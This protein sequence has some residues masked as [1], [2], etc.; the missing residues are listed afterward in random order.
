MSVATHPCAPP[1]A[2]NHHLEA[3][4]ALVQAIARQVHA[5]FRGVLSRDDLVSLGHEGLVDA[6]LRFEPGRGVEFKAYASHR[7]RGAIIDGMRRGIAAAAT[8]L[9]ACAREADRK[10]KPS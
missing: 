9:R 8:R 5:S 7:I 10:N 3:G 2:N 1:R 6:T 4:L